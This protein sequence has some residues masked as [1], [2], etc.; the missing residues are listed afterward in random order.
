MGPP[1]HVVVASPGRP[2]NRAAG[3]P[4]AG[5]R[6]PATGCRLPGTAG[7][8]LD[9]DEWLQV[10]QHVVSGRENSASRC[11]SQMPLRFWAKKGRKSRLI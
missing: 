3:L 10:V 7:H 9:L 4:A 6:L 11:S 2:A 5:Y 8:L 1:G